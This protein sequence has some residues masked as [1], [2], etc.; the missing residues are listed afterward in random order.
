M[1]YAGKSASASP[2][3][4]AYWGGIDSETKVTELWNRAPVMDPRKRQGAKVPPTSPDA[5]ENAVAIIL[6]LNNE[7]SIK[8]GSELLL[9]R[10]FCV[11]APKKRT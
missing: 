11:S 7:S 4:A 5:T 2:D 9:R 8:L 6:T 10:A 3:N 1:Q